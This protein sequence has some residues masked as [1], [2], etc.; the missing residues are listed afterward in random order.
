MSS[1]A[2]GNL[3]LQDVEYQV[4]ETS[5]GT[6]RR[7]LYPSGKVFSEYKAHRMWAGLPLV[8]YTFGRSPETGRFVT[9][10]GVLAIGRFARGYLA[11][12][13]IA[14]GFVAIGMISLGF[15]GIGWISAGLL[16]G[17]GQLTIALFSVGQI[18]FG[19]IFALGQI[20]IGHVAIGQVAVGSYVLAQ[21]GWGDH[22]WDTR[23][24]DPVAK[25]FFLS[26]IGK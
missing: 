16:L 14:R 13:L 22:V 15:I 23:A 24:V 19:A 26:L 5:S 12:G 3:L 25:Q 6:W 18:A 10:H 2:S 1:D 11:L 9:A 4:T 7:F 17:M 21:L 20:A 8:H